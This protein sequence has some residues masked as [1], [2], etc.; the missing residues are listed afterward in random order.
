MKITNKYINLA[1]H[2]FLILNILLG[3]TS[4]KKND[5]Q[6]KTN[7]ELPNIILVMADDLG[8][9]DVA[10]NGNEI[11]K[12]PHLDNMAKAGIKLNRFYAAAPV[13]SPTRASCLTG[14]HP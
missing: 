10:Y 7:D 12:T 8:W 6:T 11:V 14:R 5:Q 9:G 3:I 13:C 1:I 2:V 4:C